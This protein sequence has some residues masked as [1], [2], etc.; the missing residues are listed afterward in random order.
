MGLRPTKANESL[1]GVSA[2][3]LPPRF[4]AAR[5]GEARRQPGRGWPHLDSQRNGFFAAKW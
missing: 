4:C 5:R 2:F 3:S 1:C